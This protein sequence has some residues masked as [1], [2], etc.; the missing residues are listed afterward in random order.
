MSVRFDEK[1]QKW[2][3]ITPRNDIWFYPGNLS[4]EQA[5]QE[6]WEDYKEQMYSR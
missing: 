2:E 6:A 3:V 4:Q 5:Y 1:L